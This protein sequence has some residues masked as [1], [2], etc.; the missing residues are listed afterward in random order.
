[1]ANSMD[2][3]P[4]ATVSTYEQERSRLAPILLS[5]KTSG[6]G[7]RNAHREEML[8]SPLISLAVKHAVDHE[9]HVRGTSTA[10]MV[11]Q[12]HR[13]SLEGL[14]ELYPQYATLGCSVGS[15]DSDIVQGEPIMLNANSP[16]STFICGSQGS[17]KSYTLACMAESCLLRDE[18]LGTLKSPLA[19]LLFHY[20]VDSGNTIAEFASLCSRGIRVQVLVSRTDYHRLKAAYEASNGEHSANLSILPLLRQDHK[21]TN[22]RMQRMMSMSDHEGKTPLYM[23]VIIRILRDMALDPSPFSMVTFEALIQLQTFDRVQENFLKQRMD[24]LKSFCSSG[25][26]SYHTRALDNAI[27]QAA[28]AITNAH[29]P[30]PEFDVLQIEPGTLTIVDL[31]DPSIGTSTGCMLFDIC[32]SIA[33]EKPIT[34]GLVIALD[35]VHKYIDSCSAAT[36]FT[37]SLPNTIREQRHKGVRVIIATQEP[38]ISEKLLDL[39][40]VTIVHRFTP[41]EWLQTLKRHLSGCSDLTRGVE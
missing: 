11:E 14:P 28:R 24:L 3:Q 17:G 30:I 18:Q 23:D 41:P 29:P 40:S 27:G 7:S 13:L 21:L 32:L 8:H 39:C 9:Q 20:D 19:G 31:S 36:T 35:E 22:E 16:A 1:M 5:D 37:N 25:A 12:V 6:A 26:R 2:A 34:S 38:P 15:N 33:K 10:E 4:S